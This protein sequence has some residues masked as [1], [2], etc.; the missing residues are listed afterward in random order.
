MARYAHDRGIKIINSTNAHFFQ[1]RENID[2]LIDSRLD[3]LIIALD[4]VDPDT[5]EQYR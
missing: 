2:R 5:Y 3:V 4:G 1:N